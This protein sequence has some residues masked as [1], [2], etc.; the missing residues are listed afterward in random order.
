MGT[1]LQ[2]GRMRVL[3]FFLVV[4]VAVASADWSCQEC[5]EG[6][7]LLGAF[8]ITPSAIA[9]QA[10][11]LV[12]EL[13]P[14]ADDPETCTE[15]LPG[16]WQAL[17]D[18]IFPVHFTY[19]CYDKPECGPARK[20]TDRVSVPG[21]NDCS[22]RVNMITDALAA[23]ETI[24]G[25]IDGLQGS[26]FCLELVPDNEDGCK[27]AVEQLLPLALPLLAAQPRDWVDGFCMD[28]GCMA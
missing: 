28:W 24:T 3:T 14:Q 25:W 21:C 19:I 16:F 7:A 6:A 4:C 9:D 2:T 5:H 17:A 12:G 27:E 20:N 10:A 13:C 22:D 18:I 11:L 1:G 26:G 15:Q 23:E 8:A